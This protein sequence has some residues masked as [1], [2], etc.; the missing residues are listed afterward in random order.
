MTDRIINLCTVQNAK[1]ANCYGYSDITPYEIVRV[2]SDK[3]IEVREMNAEIDPTWKPDF[4]P[5]GFAG[6]VTNNESQRW[7]ITSDP[8]ARVLRIRLSKKGW[9]RGRFYLSLVPRYFYDYNF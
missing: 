7:I 8:T 6:T 9:G 1:F 2:I 4:V 5:G 3:T